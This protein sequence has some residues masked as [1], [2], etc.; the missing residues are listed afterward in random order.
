MTIAF[1]GPNGHRLTLALLIALLVHLL[2]LT[3]A[4][5]DMSSRLPATMPTLKV[6]LAP[7]HRGASPER[8]ET[9]PITQPLGSSLQKTASIT[10]PHA[11]TTPIT[12]PLRSTP[13]NMPHR[14]IG[15][16]AHHGQHPFPPATQ[17]VLP[18]SA[19]VTPPPLAAP[20]LARRSA[21]L[22]VASSLEIAERTAEQ[23]PHHDLSH[24][25]SVYI[26]SRSHDFKYTAYL[27]AWRIK[28]ERI[29]NMNY[30]ADAQRRRIHGS[31]VLDVALNPDGGIRDIQL[32]R[33]SGHK[34]LDE[35]A[36]NIV[37]LSAPFATFPADIRKE[38]DV[39][40]I[41]RTWQ[42][43]ADDVFE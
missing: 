14:P 39:L 27:E 15:Q 20:R 40:H 32:V 38:A 10:P 30:P 3:L 33:T 24:T 34:L 41:T 2:V 5:V 22:L 23:N 19:Q 7:Q 31:L 29:G 4:Q 11:D 8:Q 17:R 13:M 25:R 18:S 35:A 28:I 12:P 43:R 37:Q 36:K 1:F 21:A 42:F 9:T 16:E 26:S 6:F